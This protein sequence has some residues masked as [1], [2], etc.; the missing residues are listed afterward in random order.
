MTNNTNGI[1]EG[2]NERSYQTVLGYIGWLILITFIIIKRATELSDFLNNKCVKSLKYV[3]QLILTA[4]NY[5]DNCYTLIIDDVDENIP[6]ITFRQ[7]VK[8]GKD[9][10]I[11]PIKRKE[12]KGKEQQ[13]IENKHP[14]D[15]AQEIITEENQAALAIKWSAIPHET[16]FDEQFL[17]V[18]HAVEELMDLAPLRDAMTQLPNNIYEII[19]QYELIP[20]VTTKLTDEPIYNISKTYFYSVIESLPKLIR[21]IQ[22]G[23]RTSLVS[24]ARVINE[25]KEIIKEYQGLTELPNQIKKEQSQLQ[26][27]I[28][29]VKEQTA[30]QLERID[31]RAITTYTII[32]DIKSQIKKIEN[33]LENT[34]ILV[35]QS[36][37]PG[38]EFPEDIVELH[39]PDENEF[40]HTDDEVPP[41]E[42]EE[43]NVQTH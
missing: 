15:I 32:S 30:T 19:K 38:W 10:K 34:G 11:E 22:Q 24:M 27:Q 36:E 39:A 2:L 29:Q 1:W 14:W 6:L 31:K 40:F 37:Q 26:K 17:R 41:L 9:V 42:S 16:L 5:L 20:N 23:Q 43:T 8:S 4:L 7:N 12:E 13:F 35:E 3:F 21:S 33:T 28:G 18:F 25:Q